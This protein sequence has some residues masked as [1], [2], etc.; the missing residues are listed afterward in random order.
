MFENGTHFAEF[1]WTVS[2]GRDTYGYNICTLYVDGLRV[3]RCNGG[4]YDMKGTCYG[5][6]L[7]RNFAARLNSL[8]IPAPVVETCPHCHGSGF[9]VGEANGDAAPCYHCHKGKVVSETGFY[10]LT[11]HDPN[12][13]PGKAIIGRDTS[14]RTLAQIGGGS[15]EGK[16]VEQAEADGDSIGLERYQAIY[17][18]SSKFPTVLHTIPS[19]DGACG[20]SSVDKIGKAIGVRL[21]WL[22]GYNRRSKNSEKYLLTVADMPQQEAQQN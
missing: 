3:A 21:E 20:M 17:S 1:K 6:F 10:G 18:A 2:R 13:D 22:P 15:S 8:Q 12:Y 4:G 11:F 9:G 14:D 19:I 5:D 16:T 7:A